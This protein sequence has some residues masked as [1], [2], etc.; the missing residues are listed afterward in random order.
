[1]WTEQQYETAAALSE[2]ERETALDAHR[3]RMARAEPS[4]DGCCEACGE[5]IPAAR[6]AAWP[7]ARRC[8]P[9]QEDHDKRQ[10]RYARG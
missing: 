2:R 1:M 7:T 5:P 4:P 9:C 8:V 3:E 6:L 10:S